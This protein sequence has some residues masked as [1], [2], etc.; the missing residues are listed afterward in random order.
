MRRGAAPW[1]ARLPTVGVRVLSVPWGGAERRAR[2]V[3]AGRI[4]GSE[5]W[6]LTTGTEG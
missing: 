4:S 2:R 5:E 6:G 1:F 3:F